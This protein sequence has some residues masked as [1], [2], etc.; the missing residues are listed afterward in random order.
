MAAQHTAD[1]APLRGR[2]HAHARKPAPPF[3]A[4]AETL[5]EGPTQVGS[6][7]VGGHGGAAHGGPCT[8]TGSHPRSRAKACSAF[9]G[10]RRNVVRGTHASG[11]GQCR[12]TWQR[13]TRRTLHR[14]GVASTLTRES[15][16]RLSRR[17]PKRCP[18][19]PRKWDRTV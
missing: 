5:S 2:I 4:H 14:Y 6:D 8:A 13:S 16:L 10:A 19:D 7:S 11:I 12:R 3:A 17:T 9:R 15:L 18:R 1:L